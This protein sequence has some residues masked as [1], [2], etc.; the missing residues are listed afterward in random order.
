MPRNFVKFGLFL[1][2]RNL[3]L[4]IILI[5]FTVGM[6]GSGDAFAE[7]AEEQVGEENRSRLSHLYHDIYDDVKFGAKTV[8]LDAK[9]IVLLPL[10]IKKLKNIRW[11]QVV[12]GVAVAGCI[13]GTVFL[14]DEIRGVMKEIPDDTARTIQT[15]SEVALW[16]ALGGLYLGGLYTRDENWRQT[17]LTGLES[18]AVSALLAKGIKAAAGRA[19]PDSELGPYA[20][21]VGGSSFIS[22][23]TAPCFASAAAVSHA[24]EDRWWAAVP[25]YTFATGVGIGRMGLDRH[26]ASDILGSAAVGILTA[27]AFLKLHESREK[28]DSSWVKASPT[29]SLA[30]M[31]GAGGGK[32][33]GLQISF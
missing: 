8:L 22:D 28:A 11:Q 16:A 3:P 2:K 14:D 13:T 21:R 23:A 29:A 15:A 19:R 30:P 5:L 1:K 20:W 7:D 32:G 6:F 33:L 31:W 10:S 26:W 18:Y 4:G 17:S 9:D 12:I 24:F 25:L 27:K